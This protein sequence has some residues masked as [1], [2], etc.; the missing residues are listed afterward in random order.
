MPKR[1]DALLAE[2]DEEMAKLNEEAAENLKRATKGMDALILEN[3]ELRGKADH[4]RE[5]AEGTIKE[6][7]NAFRMFNELGTR[8]GVAQQWLFRE[9]ARAI[10]EVNRYRKAEGKEPIQISPELREVMSVEHQDLVAMTQEPP[11][12]K[13]EKQLENRSA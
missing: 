8:A 3:S 1:L 7:D 12:P 6:R 9:L 2:H 5:F 4:Y 13:I 10:R 11:E